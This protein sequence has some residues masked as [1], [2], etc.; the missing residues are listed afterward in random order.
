MTHKEGRAFVIVSGLISPLDPNQHCTSKEVKLDEYDIDMIVEVAYRMKHAQLM[1]S[2][3]VAA[4][5]NYYLTVIKPSNPYIISF[6]FERIQEN[7][8]NI[9]NVFATIRVALTL[10]KTTK[11]KELERSPA[12]QEYLNNLTMRDLIGRDC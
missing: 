10:A 9:L 7:N 5:L 4:V 12:E 2:E 8:K 11:N 6:R 1:R 3:I